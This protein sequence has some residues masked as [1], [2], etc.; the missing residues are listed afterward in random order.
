MERH[1]KYLK[2]RFGTAL[3]GASVQITNATTGAAAALYSDN[4]VTA[5]A[6]NTLTTDSNGKYSFYA[7]NGRYTRTTTA[8][9]YV[10]D[11]DADSILLFD[12]ADA[13]FGIV[14]K[15]IVYGAKGN[16]TTDDATA[17]NAALSAAAGTGRRVVLPYSSA[18]YLCGAQ[19]IADRCRLVGDNA[20][21]K[22]SGLGAATD[23]MVLQGSTKTG[24]APLVIEGVNVNANSVGRDAVVVAG[25]NASANRNDFMV[26][27]DMIIQGAV[28][29]G[30]HME[31]AAANYWIQNF[32][33]ADTYIYNAG[34]HGIAAI[35]PALSN[36]Y[37]NQGVLDNVDIRGAGQTTAAYDIYVECQGSSTSQ[38]ASE[39][40]LI[41]CDLDAAGAANHAQGS[42]CFSLTGSA[43]D[44]SG[45]TLIGTTPEDTG[46]RIT[47]FPNI[48]QV[49]GAPSINGVFRFGGI[50]SKYNVLIDLSK[51]SRVF[52]IDGTSNRQ[53]IMFDMG[54]PGFSASYAND[55]AAAAAGVQVG[56]L[57][58]T[59]SAVAV[60]V[61]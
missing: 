20:T 29:D 53:Q 4:G 3:A 58:R 21:L 59:A 61:T 55:A 51:A 30:I 41:S 37:I 40:T 47:G 60:R 18:T 6:S 50:T 1:E 19:V 46:S 31:P 54:S 52:N 2:N 23:C 16:G 8:A 14:V 5:L 48:I 27:R 17:I 9:N 26:L 36:V 39:W 42:I 12:P 44:I 45:W 28:R 38:K 35:V 49:V 7:A 57:Y 10:T 13:L 56:Q 24:S 32:R 22:F 11:A 25:G 43:G 33:I 34:R 15:D